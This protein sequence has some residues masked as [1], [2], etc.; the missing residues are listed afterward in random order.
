MLGLQHPGDADH[1]DFEPISSEQ[2]EFEIELSD[3]GTHDAISTIAAT[4]KI[5]TQDQTTAT[6]AQCFLVTCMDFRLID[7]IGKFMD[8]EGYNNNYDQFIL[9]GSSL[10]FT[11]EKFPHWTQSLM[12]HM[13]IGLALHDFREIIFIDHIDC[14]AFKKFYPEIK[15]REDEV[16]LHEKHMQ[17]ARD[18]LAVKFPKFNFKGYLM[19]LHGECTRLDIDESVKCVTEKPTDHDEFLSQMEQRCGEEIKRDNE[20]PAFNLKKG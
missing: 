7:D 20:E 13:G 12:D 15:S 9:A 4:S 18:R 10:G 14:G 8:K 16:P 1:E 6:S 3:I 11:Q 5:K 19:N 2:F 17:M